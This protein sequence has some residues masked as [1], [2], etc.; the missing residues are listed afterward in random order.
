MTGDFGGFG[1]QRKENYGRNEFGRGRR[2]RYNDRNDSDRGSYNDRNDSDRGRYNGRNDSDRGR[3][4]NGSDSFN[5][6]RQSSNRSW[7]QY[8]S[9]QQSESVPAPSR[10]IDWGAIHASRAQVEAEKWQGV[11][12]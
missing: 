4:R 12:I 1:G 10:T 9:D 5:G 11:Y 6:P 7:G 3:G 2:G 8:P